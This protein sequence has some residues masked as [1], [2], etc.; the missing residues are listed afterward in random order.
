MFSSDVIATLKSADPDRYR[1]ALFAETGTRDRLLVLY[2]F[3]TE[4]AKVPEIVSE[5]VIG[6]IRYQWWREVMDEIFTEQTVRTHEITQPLKELIQKCQLSRFHLDR[7]I[8]G[9]ARDLDP[10][11]FSDMDEAKTYCRNTSGELARLAAHCTGTAF[12]TEAA[13]Q[14]GLAWGLTGLAR[15]WRFYHTSILSGL[16]FDDVCEAALS[17]YDKARQGLSPLDPAL[18]PALSYIALVPKY[19]ARMRKEGIDPTRA[20]VSYS[21]VLKQLRLSR[22]TLTGH[23]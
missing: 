4:L 22:A 13:L 6:E 2:A 23:L 17:A 21:P 20:E 5:P 1:A 3:H 15:A 9:R 7:L 19:V 12:D 8:N 16:E 14:G 11:P 10:T 18:M